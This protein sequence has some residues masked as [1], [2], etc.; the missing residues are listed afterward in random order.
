M[1]ALDLISLSQALSQSFSTLA[2]SCILIAV[3]RWPRTALYIAPETLVLLSICYALRLEADWLRFFSLHRFEEKLT[4]CNTIFAAWLVIDYQRRATVTQ[5]KPADLDG[6]ADEKLDTKESDFA[7]AAKPVQEE[8]T[9]RKAQLTIN[10]GAV[11][12]ILL[13]QSFSAFTNSDHSLVVRAIRWYQNKPIPPLWNDLTPQLLLLAGML[14]AGAIFPQYSR[15]LVLRNCGGTLPQ[16]DLEVVTQDLDAETLKK[17][18]QTPWSVWSFI[19]LTQLPAVLLLPGL[20]YNFKEGHGEKEALLHEIVARGAQLV[21]FAIFLAAYA[22]LPRKTKNPQQT[23]EEEQKLIE[24][25]REQ[26]K[27]EVTL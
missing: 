17:R 12:T 14:Q 23:G 24:A 18:L 26:T 4:L 13:I 6:Q 5:R 27:P 7:T 11:R 25:P 8:L 9:K 20:I 15:V 3:S 2:T 10:W 21:F 1:S 16:K 19:W 22:I